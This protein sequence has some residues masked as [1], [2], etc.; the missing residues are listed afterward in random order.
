MEM[1]GQA[2]FLA[3][4][5]DQHAGR[6]WPADT[7]HVLDADDVGAGFFQLAGH[8]DVIPEVVLRAGRVKQVAGIAD[9][10]LADGAR[11]DHRVHGDPHVVDPVQRIEDPEDV[12]AVLRRL[13]H[14]IAHHI[15]RVVGVANSVGSPQQHLQQ[16]VGRRFAQLAQPFPGIFLE[17]AHGDVEGGATPAFQREQV[18]Q[19]MCIVRRDGD[20]VRSPHARGEQRL[21]GVTHGGVGEQDAL[22]VAH[23]LGKF[24]RAE[25]QK[26]VTA[27]LGQGRGRIDKWQ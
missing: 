8:G 27:A 22:L 10:R 21:V 2:D 11:F 6:R 24:L 16:H 7:G 19:Q 5:L 4:C 14:E 12:H 17:E 20:H 3:D 1:D 9:R 23:P 26:A 18:G 15:V 25:F 13:G